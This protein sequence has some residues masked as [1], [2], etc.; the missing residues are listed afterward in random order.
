[1]NIIITG[2]HSGIGLELT[3]KLVTEG[4][5]LGLIVRTIKRTENMPDFVKNY[6][7][8]SYFEAD[9]SNQKS[10]LEV[11]KQISEKWD[12][13]DVLFNNA[14]VLLDANYDSPQGN[15]MHFEVNTLAP[16]VLTHA[17]K[18]LLDHSENPSVVNTVT[19]GMHAQ[20]KLDTSLFI[21]PTRFIKLFGAYMQSK[22]AL[23]L[24]MNE[25]AQKWQN[26]RIVNVDPG[27]NKTKMTQESG[28]PRWLLPLR[29]LF[30][31]KPRKGGELLHKGA[32][33][34][35]HQS[36]SGIYLTSNKAKKIRFDL[37]EG[38]KKQMLEGLKVGLDSL[39]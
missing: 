39:A 15:E 27:P 37:P 19:G 24:F 12:K 14:G 28:M 29:N 11:A 4:H 20:S 30:F 33:D 36:K 1:M 2:G 9:L 18:P 21:Q 25:L 5:Q 10:I 22:L 3:K 16:Y 17:L 32:F 31:Q 8:I 13:V 23:V 35:K 7:H 26:I 38:D 6:G 34:K